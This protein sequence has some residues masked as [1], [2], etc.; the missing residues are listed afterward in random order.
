[1]SV[2]SPSRG[3]AAAV[4]ELICAYDTALGAPADA[5]AADVLEAWREIDLDRDAWLF[6]EEGRV[7][8]FGSL[9]GSG[10]ERLNIDGYV[11]PDFTGRGLG[12]EILRV[13][14][15]RVRERAA[16][17][18]H[19]GMLHADER[20]HALLESRGYAFVRAFLRMEIELAEQ[21]PSPAVP[22]GLELVSPTRDDDV[23]V[24]AAAEEAFLDH[25][26][27]APEELDAWQR[28]HAG[29]DRSLWFAMR[30]G[31]ELAAVAINDFRF[32]NG[33]VGVLGTRRPWRGRGIA[34][35]LLLATFGE[36]WRRGERTVRLSVDAASPTGAVRLYERVGMHTA[37]RAD[38]YEKHL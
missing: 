36:F 19:V 26:E 5:S 38:V 28:R 33:W 24:H 23:A 30:D 2:R 7:V 8:A 20:A 31:E 13:G 12:G 3:D 10:P 14:E 22:E 11:H 34:Q 1:V 21:P 35:A 18:I 17:R 9:W 37:W 16:S 4:A 25:W 32:G 29:T 27:H 15:Q 6:E